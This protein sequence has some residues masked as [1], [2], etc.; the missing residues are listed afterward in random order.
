VSAALDELLHAIS[1]ATPTAAS[2]PRRPIQRVFMKR[3]I[4]S[5][6]LHSEQVAA[7]SS[8]IA[9]TSIKPHS[10]EQGVTGL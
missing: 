10:S 1:M 3:F 8:E 6:H 4:A 2:M 5:S 7:F 9:A